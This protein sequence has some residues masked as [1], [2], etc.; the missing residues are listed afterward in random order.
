MGPWFPGH[1]Q[2]QSPPP[3]PGTG[4]RDADSRRMAQ[5]AWDTAQLQLATAC[6]ALSLDDGMQQLLGTPRR[7]MEVA[8]PLRRDTGAVEVLTG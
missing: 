3:N 8:V 7:V 5:D 6:E 1:C 4:R 2:A